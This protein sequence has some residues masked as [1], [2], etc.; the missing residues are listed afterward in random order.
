MKIQDE[1]SETDS[2][3][4]SIRSKYKDSMIKRAQS[5]QS[6]TKLCL[7]IPPMHYRQSEISDISIGHSWLYNGF[8]ISLPDGDMIVDPGLD[9]MFRLVKSTYDLSRVRYIFV[10]HG[11]IDH[12]AGL[13]PILDW[14][15]R[16]G[17]KVSLI[18]P[19]SFLDSG[20]VS[21]YHLGK[22]S[23][24][25]WSS[26]I[27]C[28][29]ILG[30]QDIELS[31]KVQ[32]SPIKLSHGIDCFGFSIN[33]ST[34]QLNYISDTGMN[35]DLGSLIATKINGPLIINIDSFVETKNS[36]THMCVEALLPYLERSKNINKIVLGHINPCGE[37][38]HESWA[39]KIAQYVQTNTGI[40]CYAPSQKGLSIDMSDA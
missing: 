22:S 4:Q 2:L 21:E 15:I 8:V 20:L 23:T 37:I 5:K 24:E 30:N 38:P 34:G 16:A 27:S 19:K 35:E 1:L 3:R 36:K 6:C 29:P 11:H 7:S 10:S 31:S 32:L 28:K 25:K 40:E 18:A 13:S 26:I 14:L 33:T 39:K 9:F 12:Y 17:S